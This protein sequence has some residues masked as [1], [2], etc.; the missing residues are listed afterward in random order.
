[1]GERMRRAGIGLVV[2]AC[3]LLAF[4]L[5][6]YSR[7]TALGDTWSGTWSRAE[8]GVAGNLILT[9]SGDPA[10][11][12]TSVSGHYT[13]NDG[14]GHVSGTVKGATFTGFFNETHYQGDFALTLSADGK[15]FTGSYTGLNKDTN[16][17]IS[18]P[19]D[20]TCIAG[21]CLRN[22]PPPP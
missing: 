19:F 22:S 9:Q 1:Y 3:L 21:E 15:K 11:G 7:V 20:G 4:P 5:A 2:V 14:S 8:D 13:W 12:I 10:S 16:A 17:D 6:S 18:G